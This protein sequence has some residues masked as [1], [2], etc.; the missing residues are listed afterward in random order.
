MTTVQEQSSKSFARQIGLLTATMLIIASMVGT[1]VFTTTGF[2]I[3]D[4]GSPAGVLA[5]WGVGGIIAL[6]GALSYAELVTAL[7][8]NGGEYLL[9][10]RIYH[11]L[12]GFMA[13]WTSLVVGFSAPIAASALA[14]SSY[15]QAVFPGSPS[16]VASVLLVALLSLLHALRMAEGGGFQNVF[17]IGKVVLISAFIVGGIWM[18]QPSRIL[19]PQEVGLLA[20]LPTSAFAVGLIFVTFSYSGWNAAVY[21]AGEVRNPRRNLP[22]ALILGTGLVTVLYISLNVVFLGAVPVAELSG[23]IEVGHVAARSLFG[24]GA[25][26]VLS[27]IIALGLISTVGALIMTGPRVYEAMGLD[28]SRLRFFTGRARNGGPVVAT[29]VQGA[30][31][32]LMMLTASFDTLLTY[33]GFTVSIFAGLTVLGVFVLRFREPGLE[34]PYRT[35]GY[36]L[37]P[38]LFV[39]LMAWM[40]FHTLIE[41]PFSAVAGL[42][43]LGL[44]VLIYLFVSQDGSR[45]EGFAQ[46]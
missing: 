6:A 39:L 24:E 4:I 15:M 26:R 42:I 29:V 13:G 22:L 16:T 43:T 44:G 3:R 18:G 27:A 1:G 8:S 14:F 2:L 28:Y 38:A 25:A 33:V 9:L 37:T 19:E 20:S 10:S 46:K 32:V 17:T 36:P 30:I 12:V 11:P 7:P 5:C 21:L 41:K 31:A 35:W 40:S 34:R 23:V 45:G